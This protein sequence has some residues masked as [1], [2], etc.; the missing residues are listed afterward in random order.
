MG[1]TFSLSCVHDHD[2]EGGGAAPNPQQFFTP[3]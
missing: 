2:R 3:D 1:D